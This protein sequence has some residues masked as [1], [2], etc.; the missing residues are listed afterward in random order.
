MTSAGAGPSVGKH[1]LM[2]YLPP[3]QAV[4]GTELAVEYLGERYPVTVAVAGPTPIFDPEN[5]DRPRSPL[6][7]PGLHQAGADDR[8]PDRAH[9]RR[10][11][12]RDPSPRVHDQPPRG[13]RGRGGGAHGRAA[14]R[15]PRRCSR[16]ARRRP[17]SSCATRW[18][19][20]S[21]AA[22]IWSPTTSGIRRRRPGRSSTRRDEAAA[23]TSY[24]VIVF[25]NESPDAGNYQV[26]I[27]VAHALGLPC[28]T[29]LKGIAV[30]DGRLRCEQEV[31][32]GRDVY[33]VPLAA[34]VTVLEGL[35]LPRY[36]SVPAE[37][38][39]KRSRSTRA[40]RSA[41][42]RASR[43]CGWCAR[44][45]RASR[46]R[47]SAM[48]PRRHRRW[49]GCSGRRGCLMGIL[50]LVEHA[51]GQPSSC[52]CRRSRSR[53]RAPGEPVDAV[54]VERG[55]GGGRRARQPRRR[56]GV[57]G[58][59]SRLG[60]YAP[61]AWARSLAAL[62]G[63]ISPAAVIAAGLGARERAARPRGRVT[64][65]RSPPTACGRRA[66]TPP[67]SRGCAG[68][69][70][71]SRKPACTDGSSCSRWRRTP[72]SRWWSATRRRHR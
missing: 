14:R 3:E 35:N 57:R 1:L 30:E 47:S 67:P 56:Q 62:A 15:R 13:V 69:G 72:P 63:Q 66:A 37:L 40:P 54:L 7:D 12:D 65:C 34:V 45:V 39:A 44:T 43:R 46:R 58:R 8:R 27:R 16:S 64:S 49:S 2:A 42:R 50:V 24:D 25:G 48:A 29:G 51:D 61:R 70:A 28:V 36:P 17:R 68:A 10:A 59:R 18:R 22:S 71:C 6:N 11:G 5:E 21:T 23:G 33:R 26:G 9:P 19:S 4:E 41:R 55:R 32:G 31:P 52:R 20:A 53:V 38:R 60:A